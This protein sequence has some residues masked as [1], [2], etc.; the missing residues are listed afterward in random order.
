MHSSAQQ[1]LSDIMTLTLY[2]AAGSPPSRACLLLLRTLKL[3]VNV[4]TLNLAAGEQNTPEFLKLNPLHQVPVL[5]DGDF[6][7]TEGRA[8]LAYLVN[9]YSPGSSLYPTDPEKRA[10]IDQRLFYD[11]TVVFESAAQIIVRE[12]VEKI[13][14]RINFFSLFSAQFCTKK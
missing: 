1:V 7:L 14:K 2:F 3:E 6:V 12:R 4:K 9:K 11:S 5:T 8:I 13:R 10:R